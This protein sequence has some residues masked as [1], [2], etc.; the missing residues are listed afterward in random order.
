M[1]CDTVTTQSRII[2]PR[3][4]IF[5]FS[6]AVRPV[7]GNCHINL[8][9]VTWVP[10]FTFFPA[11][12]FVKA[13]AVNC[14]VRLRPDKA[15]LPRRRRRHPTRV[16]LLNRLSVRLRSGTHSFVLACTER[17][18]YSCKRVVLYN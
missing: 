14:T 4:V 8:G 9:R 3:V 7:A 13:V 17:E 12:H 16:E 6:L 10:V 11:R 15:G 1:R 18:M 2:N 5:F